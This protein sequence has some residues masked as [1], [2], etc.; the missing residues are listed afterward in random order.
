[1]LIAVCSAK[2]SPGVTTSTLALALGWRRRV[3]LAE[4]DP[5]GGDVL[6]GYGQG[7]TRTGT[8]GLIDLM[9]AARRGTAELELWTHL[10]TLDLEHRAFVL[11]GLAEARTARAIDWPRLVGLLT[12]SRA[13]VLAD[14]GRFRAEHVPRAVLYAADLVLLVCR[15]TLRSV[16]SAQPAIAELTAELSARGT[17]A[18]ALGV[19]LIDPGAP[20]GAVEVE[21]A[22]GVPVVTTLP[23]D[24]RAAAVLSDGAPTTRGFA[25]SPLLKAGKRAATE[26]FAVAGARRARLTAV[27]E[28]GAAMAIGFDRPPPA[29]TVAAQKQPKAA[30]ARRVATPSAGPWGEAIAA[31]GQ[32][33]HQ[34]R[35][36]PRWREPAPLH[37]PGEP[38]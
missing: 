1:M 37:G 35:Q 5:A 3:V 13:D 11:P 20:F 34:S 17:G 28:A 22:L 36:P 21:K 38:R 12:G 27:P 24:A 19:L 25:T 30:A 7:Q 8:E 9:A 26:T 32:S 14:C 2:G 31:N 29:V 18:D 15:A 10:V 23:A 4:C 33:G 16:R 6:A